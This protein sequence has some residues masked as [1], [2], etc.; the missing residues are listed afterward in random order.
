MNHTEQEYAKLEEDN[1]Q[2]KTA[3]KQ[4]MDHV[5]R[6]LPIAEK[7]KQKLEKIQEFSSNEISMVENTLQHP[8]WILDEGELKGIK[9]IATEIL[10]ILEDK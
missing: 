6:V 4:A 7:Q 3:I 1:H 10:K 9:R 8:D 2:L 5:D